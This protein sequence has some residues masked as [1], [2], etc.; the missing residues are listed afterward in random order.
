MERGDVQDN[1]IL[2]LAI[3]G[4]AQIGGMSNLGQTG[5]TAGV[6]ADITDDWRLTVIGTY[7]WSDSNALNETFNATALA[8]D[9]A[10]V[11]AAISLIPGRA[12]CRGTPVAD[13]FDVRQ[14]GAVALRMAEDGVSLHYALDGVGAR[15]WSPSRRFQR[16]NG[17][18]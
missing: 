18:G 11:D 3:E 14:R 17:T 10:A 15:P 5:A 12:F 9:C 8:Q 4:N 13:L 7:G 1:R 2:G 16:R 6:E